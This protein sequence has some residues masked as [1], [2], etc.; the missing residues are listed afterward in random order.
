MFPAYKTNNNRKSAQD[1][2]LQGK[3]EQQQR[4]FY[5]HLDLRVCVRVCMVEC[6]KVNIRLMVSTPHAKIFTS[7]WHLLLL[8]FNIFHSIN[9]FCML[10]QHFPT[11]KQ[12]SLRLPPV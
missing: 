6:V 5:L 2:N 3:V 4:H 1:G 9:F 12:F 8:R 7:T 10:R 11:D